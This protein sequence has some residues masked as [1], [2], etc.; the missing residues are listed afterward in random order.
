MI[1][2]TKPLT[3]KSIS[4]QKQQQQHPY[5]NISTTKS[6]NNPQASGSK[7]FVQ[8]KYP[9]QL[10]ESEIKIH[11]Q[12]LAE[13]DLDIYDIMV[14]LIET[15]KPNLSLYKQQPYLTFT[16]RLKLIDFLLKMSIR[17]KILPFV[18]FKAVK[19]FDRYC[20][21][22]IVLLDQSQLIITTCLWIAS[23]VMGGNNHFVNINNLD[24]IGQ[25]NFR[26]INDLGYGCGGKYLGPTERF[27]LPKL[28][29]LVKLCG[30][31]CKYDQGMFKQMEVHVLNTLEW[32]LND[33]SIEEFIID[34]HEFNVIN[35]NNNNEYEQTI[36]TN[37]ESANANANA[38]ANDGN[39]FFK[40]K[41]FLSYAALY[42][43]DLIDTNIIELGQ[44]I[45]DLINETFQ[46][47]PFDKHYQTILNCDSDHPI[48]FDM[49][50]YKH[51]KKAVIKSVL[52][53]SD[54]MM[55]VFHSKGPQ[56]IYQQF[57]LQYKLNYTTNSIIGGFG[58][59]GYSPTTITTATT[60]SD[61]ISTTPTSST[62]STTPVSSY[63]GYANSRS[64]SVSSTSSVASSSNAN[65]PSSSC[66]TT[67]TTPLGMTPHK[68]QKNYSNYSNYSNSSTSL[69]L[70]NNNN[71]NTTISPV[72]STTIN[73]HTKNSSQLNY[74]YHN[75]GSN[76][77]NHHHHHKPSLSVSIP[78]PQMHS[79]HHSSTV[80]QMVT[81]PNLA[82]KNSNKSNS[83]NNNNTTTIATTTT[84]TT[85]NN[86]NSQL[87]APHQLSYNNYFNS[88]NM[89]PP[90]PMKYT[91]GR[92]QQQ[93]QNQGQNQQ[94][95]LQLYQGDNNNNG[96]N[97]NSKFNSIAGSRA[98]SSS[99][100]AVSIASSISTNNYD[101]Y[102]DD[103]DDDNSNDL[104][105]SSRRFMNY[106]NYSSSTINGSVMSG[107][108]N[109]N[110]GN[111][112][113][114]GNG[115][116]GTPISE[117]D[118]PIYTKTRLCNMIH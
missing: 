110:S 39:E 2:I 84:T 117:N 76:N 108:I 46:L 49:Q 101:K 42:S 43:H 51:I 62:G 8:E 9:S 57:N 58:N 4:Q 74:Q 83:A 28:H 99:S 96:T 3:P 104:F 16:I 66:S 64:S 68:R 50:R 75:G 59:S 10:Y 79:H 82:N 44:V 21:K 25:E 86:N 102:D 52:N 53:A 20:S 88:P 63:I 26:T 45:M 36:T 14:N 40:I 24:K 33:P 31:K 37:D 30:A 81:P 95:P 7:S 35:I 113:G 114:N 70:T 115:G 13:Y 11:N 118:S 48:R 98:V 56:F 94:Q 65:T 61:N 41:E 27:R 54:F 90:P 116:S 93:Q 73:S 38:N 97:T 19:I 22:R 106:S 17:L 23:K 103:D 67:S 72:D 107:V 55:K 60:T 47:Q 69:G 71:N 109:N 100:S 105:S 12:S 15:N 92:K 80:Y 1:N 29:E 6:N 87:P 91:P 78:P 85:N 112:K 111:G 32:S 89:Q 34:S 18:F 5:K 77:N